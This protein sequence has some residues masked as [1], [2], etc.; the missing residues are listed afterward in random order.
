[1]GTKYRDADIRW[2]WLEER[3]INVLGDPH[4]YAYMQSLW[5]HPEIVQGVFCN[6]DA[7]TGKTVLAA[8]AGYYEV[9]KGELYDK[10]IYVRNTEVVGK[11]VGFLPGDIGEKVGPHMK[12]IKAAL[13]LIKPGTFEKLV[14]DEQ[15]FCISPT[16]ERGVTYD[17]AFVI[18][19]ECQNFSLEEL[20]AEHTRPTDTCKIVSIG[21][22]AQIDDL[23]LR[24]YSGLTPFELY[25]LHYRGLLSVVHKLETNYRGEWSQHGDKIKETIA[26]LEKGEI[27]I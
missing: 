13:D 18:M 19:D 9:D 14:A 8:L 5:A 11:D 16:H 21:S 7:G 6:A 4:Q 10:I 27:T 17:R 3:G 15:L 25:A 2:K 23:K 1:M 26:K 22:T 12:P 20:Q 24:K